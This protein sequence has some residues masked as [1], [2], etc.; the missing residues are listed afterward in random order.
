VFIISRKEEK[1]F[2]ME[3]GVG[4]T[5]LDIPRELVDATEEDSGYW[6]QKTFERIKTL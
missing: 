1:L 3:V 5:G 4:G 2:G 6:G